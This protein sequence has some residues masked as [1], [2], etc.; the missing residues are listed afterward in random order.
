VLKRLAIR[1]L[2]APGMRHL[3]WPL[4]RRRA[5][6]F[7]LHR[8][9]MPDLGVEGHDSAEL[10][11]ILAELRRRHYDLVDLTTLFGALAAGRPFAR[12]TVAFTIDDGYVDQAKIGAPVFA[13]YDCPVTTFVTSGFLDGRLFFWWDRIEYAFGHTSCHDAAVVLD[14]APLRYEWIGDDTRRAAQADFTERC[15]TVPDAE[16]HAAID[17]LAA[18]LGVEIPVT[19][20][21]NYA[22][23]SWDDLRHCERHG[24][25]FGP[26]TV[27]HPVL[28]RTTDE[29]SRYELTEGWTRLRAEARNPVPVFCYPNGQSPDFG[30]REISTLGSLGFAGAVMGEYGYADAPRFQ[31]GRE[32]AFRVHRFSYSG[33]LG[34]MFQ[35]ASGVERA[36]Q[37]L[38]RQA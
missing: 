37:L 16:K 32:G 13:Q 22:P 29:Q 17:R 38:R 25:T 12:P 33:D 7:M 21:A 35:A 10:A 31:Q 30:P 11:R 27:T 4:L 1:T 14:G 20:P 18:A 26:H 5:S 34:T 24:M 3:F 8:F 6:I 9:R 19:P 28:S 15:K 2:T 23:M 36:K